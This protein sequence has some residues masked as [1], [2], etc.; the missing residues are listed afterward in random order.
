VTQH[1]SDDQLTAFWRHTLPD[2]ARRTVSA[3]LST[4]ERC[5]ARA[6]N[7][8]EWQRDVAAIALALQEEVAHP[9]YEELSAYADQ[10][11]SADDRRKVAVHAEE[12]DDCTATLADFAAIRAGQPVYVAAAPPLVE[13]RM[14]PATRSLWQRLV[15]TERPGF[16]VTV[17]GYACA[18]LLAVVASWL[19][20]Q[21]ERDRSIDAAREAR[22]EAERQES[23]AR[24]A[25]LTAAAA[26]PPQ[27]TP[28][29]PAAPSLF[30][31]ALT[32]G[33][34][35]AA[36]PAPVRIPAGVETLAL[37]LRSDLAL[38]A[39]R[40]RVAIRPRAGG[41]TLF[42]ADYPRD[43]IRATEGARVSMPAAVLPPGSYVVTLSAENKSG[44][45][46]I[47][48]YPLRIVR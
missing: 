8:G 16:W 18:M 43:A 3:H 11:L 33:I 35:R 41:D 1:V 10:T 39:P 25:V 26:Q 5:R 38:T 21:R 9:S 32:P 44:W 20:V 22:W 46:S 30:A 27:Q 15:G 4:C 31:L 48:D 29:G 17:T 47:D 2:A 36:E 13:A 45:E 40:Y 12:C 37:E 23:Q 19:Y 42:Q 7:G 6:L 14:P 34:L 24:I 28:S